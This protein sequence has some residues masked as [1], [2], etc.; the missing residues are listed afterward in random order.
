MSAPDSTPPPGGALHEDLH[1]ADEI[2]GPSDRKFGLTMATVCVV[3][4]TVRLVFGHSHWAWWLGAAVAFGGFALVSPGALGPF[5]RAWMKFGLV[6]HKIVNPVVMAL[7]YYSTIVPIGVVM[8]LCG[9]DTLRLRREPDAASYWIVR[10]PAGPP[11]ESM[12]NQF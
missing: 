6:L 8:R 3:I 7:L 5:N 12:R 1:R 9:K 10:E 11:L 4:G 2:V